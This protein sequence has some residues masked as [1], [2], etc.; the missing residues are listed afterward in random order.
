MQYVRASSGAA[1]DLVQVVELPHAQGPK[2]F[3][4]DEEWLAILRSTHSL[5][6][7]QRRPAPLPGAHAS[8]NLLPCLC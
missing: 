1:P 2:E 4:Y 6:S 8:P 7:L 3:A 5:L